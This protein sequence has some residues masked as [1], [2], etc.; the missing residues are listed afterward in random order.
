[1]QVIA[2]TTP[3]CDANSASH[4]QLK[5]QWPKTL[6]IRGE[7]TCVFFDTRA[8][9]VVVPEYSPIDSRARPY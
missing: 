2:T 5:P 9:K 4:G 3:D 1:M 7:L 8:T 6:I